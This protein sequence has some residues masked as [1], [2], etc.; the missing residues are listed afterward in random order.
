MAVVFGECGRECLS[1]PCNTVIILTTVQRVYMTGPA[2]GSSRIADLYNAQSTYVV[3]IPTREL[4]MTSNLLRTY[5][6]LR[7][8]I[9]LVI[10]SSKG[11]WEIFADSVRREYF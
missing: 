5:I 4:G 8:V 6:F 11:L 1:G 9:S 2:T 7:V 10:R 3:Y